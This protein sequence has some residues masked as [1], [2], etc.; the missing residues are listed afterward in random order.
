MQVPDDLV[1]TDP[2]TNRL[3]LRPQPSLGRAP[4]ICGDHSEQIFARYR[5]CWHLDGPS[6]VVRDQN[7]VAELDRGPGR[8]EVR[9]ALALEREDPRDEAIPGV[10]ADDEIGLQ[11][12]PPGRAV[13]LVPR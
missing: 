11:L 6:I 12:A 3:C 2:D 5:E 7:G 1:R 10:G 13:A 9:E 8:E 4:W